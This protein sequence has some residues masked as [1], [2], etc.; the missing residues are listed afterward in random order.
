MRWKR[1]ACPICS[2]PY[3]GNELDE[4]PTKV[5][6]VDQSTPA[7]APE[8]L[9]AAADGVTERGR[10]WV[11]RVGPGI[12]CV[13]VYVDVDGAARGLEVWWPL[14]LGDPKRRDWEQWAKH[15]EDRHERELGNAPDRSAPADVKPRRP[16]RR[17]RV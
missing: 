17:R 8:E 5:R 3:D 4:R 6:T 11:G 13:H 1:T 16:L 7:P 2:R 12:G 10:K 9:P 14:Q 15:V